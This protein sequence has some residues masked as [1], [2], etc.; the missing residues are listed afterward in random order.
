[1]Y[2]RFAKHSTASKQDRQKIIVDTNLVMI[3]VCQGRLGM[4]IVQFIHGN[5]LPPMNSVLIP[6]QAIFS[7]NCPEKF[8]LRPFRTVKE[9]VSKDLRFSGRKPPVILTGSRLL[10]VNL[11]GFFR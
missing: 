10:H 4:Q 1:M 7:L 5:N 11:S 9:I 3:W 8:P 2:V 6:R